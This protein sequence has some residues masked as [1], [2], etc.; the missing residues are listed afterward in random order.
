MI[1]NRVKVIR[2]QFDPVEG[3]LVRSDATGVV[4]HKCYGLDDEK[5]F[6]PFT[7]IIEIQDKGRMP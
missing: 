7:R 1:G 4:I 6:I 3:V 5:V 2:S